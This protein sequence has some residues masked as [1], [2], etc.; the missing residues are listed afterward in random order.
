MPEWYQSLSRA[1]KESPP[2]AHRTVVWSLVDHPVTLA[3]NRM[4]GG[5]AFLEVVCG[6]IM[7]A[8]IQPADLVLFR[9][10]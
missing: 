3:P 7:L 9:D 2:K 4:W 8:Q 6:L 1:I 5:S 10:T